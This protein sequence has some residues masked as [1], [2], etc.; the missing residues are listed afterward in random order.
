MA[1]LPR[2]RGDQPRQQVL[3]NGA[4]GDVKSGRAAFSPTHVKRRNFQ[5]P[6]RGQRRRGRQ[7]RQSRN[8]FH[9]AAQRV[10]SPGER[11]YNARGSDETPPADKSNQRQGSD[12]ELV[13]P[14]IGIERGGKQQCPAD[15][16]QGSLPSQIPRFGSGAPNRGCPQSARRDTRA[17]D[18]GRARQDPKTQRPRPEAKSKQAGVSRAVQGVRMSPPGGG[19]R[20]KA[21]RS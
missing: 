2:S 9:E 13:H 7:E 11:A 14:G 20:Y 8:P 19:G 21:C 17:N 12:A 1:N 16:R 15:T 6:R 10:Q 5:R 4:G 18:K 3:P